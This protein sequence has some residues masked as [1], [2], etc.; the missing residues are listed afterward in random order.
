M[1]KKEQSPVY[2]PVFLNINN[3]RCV[4]IGGGQVALRKVKALLERGAKVDVISPELCSELIN[5][6]ESR[7]IHV[8]RKHYQPGDLRGAFLAIAAT[9]DSEINCQVAE[10]ARSQAVLVNVV[11]DAEN[12]D[13]ISPAT[14]RRGDVTIAVSTA[15]LSP[16]LA[17][18]IRTKLE[19]DFGKEYGA[20]VQLV[21]EVRSEMKQRGIRIKRETWQEA[22]EL[23]LL[24]SLVKQGQ[25]EKARELLL[26][27]LIHQQNKVRQA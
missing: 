16:A 2:Y 9:N 7:Q 25:R 6:A 21:N 22:L 13:F 20:L 15:G 14:V 5:L 8:F 27:H 3:K 12:S 4:V 19:Q 11:D 10:E 26:D 18:K 23:D 1:R 24:T 17:R